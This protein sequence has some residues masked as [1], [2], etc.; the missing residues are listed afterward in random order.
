MSA[1]SQSAAT[2]GGG[3]E[4]VAKDTRSKLL[5]GAE[6]DRHLVVSRLYQ[7]PPHHWA[8]RPSWVLIDKM[9]QSSL[10]TTRLKM[11]KL[12]SGVSGLRLK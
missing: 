10:K 8:C 1:R 9:R 11:R 2:S 5:T 4:G 6:N 7:A 12:A 3:R